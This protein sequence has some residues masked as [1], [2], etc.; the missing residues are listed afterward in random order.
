M[1]L[2]IW[3]NNKSALWQF[4]GWL[5]QSQTMSWSPRALSTAPFWH[6]GKTLSRS[7]RGILIG[8]HI[9]VAAHFRH[10]QK[11]SWPSYMTLVLGVCIASILRRPSI[12]FCHSLLTKL[13]H[14]PIV[15]EMI[16]KREA[17]FSVIYWYL[18]PR[19]GTRISAMLQVF[20]FPQ[21]LYFEILTPKDHCRRRWRFRELIR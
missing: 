16:R 13:G 8:L 15:K 14:M 20:M 5:I 3:Y 17:M 12:D 9:K 11:R 19:V 21:N 18:L 1:H 7:E 4:Q 2:I 10:Y 6:L